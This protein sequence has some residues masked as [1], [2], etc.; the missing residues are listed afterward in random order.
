[1]PRCDPQSIWP[2][3]MLKPASSAVPATTKNKHYEDDD[4]EKCGAVHVTLL[5]SEGWLAASASDE[6]EQ[7]ADT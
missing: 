3:S 2:N 4:D 6:A 1:M 5:R 7:E